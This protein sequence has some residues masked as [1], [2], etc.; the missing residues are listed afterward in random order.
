MRM[1]GTQR[2]GRFTSLARCLVTALT[3][4]V[5]FA[6]ASVASEPDV[7]PAAEQKPKPE[8]KG[9]Q[10]PAT[11]VPT[12]KRITIRNA[13]AQVELSTYRASIARM[14]LMSQHPVQ[15]PK[16]RTSQVK[17]DTKAPLSILDGFDPKADM[18][19]FVEKM[20][21]PT[22]PSDPTEGAW[23]VDTSAD[24]AEATFTMTLPAKSLSYRMSY[25]MD[26]KKPQVH[27]RLTVANAGEKDFSVHPQLDAINGV[28]QDDP[29]VEAGYQRIVFHAGG[30]DGKLDY[31]DFPGTGATGERSGSFDYVGLKSRFFA[32]WWTPEGV[33]LIAPTTAAATTDNSDK[34]QADLRSAN[35]PETGTPHT[36]K[37]VYRGVATKGTA[38]DYHQASFDV[39]WK[40]AN[41]EDFI[42][43]PGGRLELAWAISVTCMTRSELGQLSEAEK[44]MEYTDW[45]YSFFKSLAKLITWT[46]NLIVHVVQYYGIAVILLTFL[47][48]AL[49]HRFTHKQYESTMKMQKLAPE[50]KYLQE[51]YKTDKQKLAMKQMELWKKHG[52]NP[53]GGCLPMFI[54]IPIFIAL[55]QAFSHCADMRGQPFLW[56]RDLTLPDQIWY[57]G[58]HI[59]IIGT[60][61]TINP[62]PIL[63]IGATVWMSMMQKPPPGGDPQQEQ[64]FKMMRWLPVIFGIIFYN[65]PAGLVLYFT[66]QAV[67]TTIE[68][69][70]VKKRLG[71]T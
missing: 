3:W 36:T 63:Y 20:G 1:S 10:S 51:Q 50:L 47:I 15:L 13:A 6:G 8:Q 18:H 58:F 69:K 42:I 70:L 48:K 54:Q 11:T 4:M 31:V 44:R 64:M 57:L 23:A 66:V 33:A 2:P 59:P 30:P 28:H 12:W 45:Y 21:L 19:S 27:V 56:V 71:M 41:G 17:V 43:A 16:W 53:L 34:G 35:T 9:E 49:L 65:M 62:L 61:A 46:L 5:V 25:R 40:P 60:L 68:I 39:Q 67:L 52:V 37:I 24:G 55:Y 29:I 22:F 26:E 7:A 38:G 14:F 32:A